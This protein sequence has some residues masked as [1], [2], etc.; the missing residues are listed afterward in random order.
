MNQHVVDV[1]VLRN[2]IKKCLEFTQG[3][4]ALPILFVF[5]DYI[6]PK[7]ASAKYFI[8]KKTGQVCDAAVIDFDNNTVTVNPHIQAM[9]E[10]GQLYIQL[11]ISMGDKN[12]FTFDQ[13]YK[14]LKTQTPITSESA[15]P[16]IDDTIKES[17]EA[18]QMAMDAADKANETANEI[19]KKSQ[20]GDYSATVT[21]GEV[22][23]VGPGEAAVVENVGTKQRVVL[24]FK[25][26]KG[27][28]GLSGVTAPANGMF[29]LWVDPETGNLY[30]DYPDEAEAPPFR[31]DSET[32]NLYYDIKKG[33]GTV[34][35]TLI[36]NVRN[37][38]I[39]N[40]TT[41]T[42]GKG[43]LDAAQGFVIAEKLDEIKEIL[44][45]AIITE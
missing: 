12:L 45:T 5:K 15:M 31:Y 35:T 2:T 4:N 43:A 44:K 3:T 26:P 40:L 21:V 33:D 18:T 9:T 8:Q 32:G 25:I 19:L 16:I 30:V 34:A 41:K 7:G 10:A 22:L 17:K 6:I 39:N 38:L 1:Y 23:T 42:A 27:A 14:V 11:Q 20:N 29:T 28:Q 13:P 36:G 37:P 24:D